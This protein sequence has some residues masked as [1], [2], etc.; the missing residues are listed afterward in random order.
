MGCRGGTTLFTNTRIY[1]IIGIAD[2]L[3]D[4]EIISIETYLNNYN[5]E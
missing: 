5:V 2:Q 3:T 1:N 4:N